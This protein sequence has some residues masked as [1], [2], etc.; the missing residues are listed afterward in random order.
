MS[1]PHP[2]ALEPIIVDPCRFCRS[3]GPHLDIAQPR[4]GARGDAFVYCRECKASGPIA[5][6]VET[7]V[8]WWNNGLIPQRKP[9]ATP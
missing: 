3:G 6:S 8:D 2:E 7:A 9:E 4:G 5:P 1:K